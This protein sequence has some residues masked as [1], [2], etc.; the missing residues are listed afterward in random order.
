MRSDLKGFPWGVRCGPLVELLLP[1]LELP[2]ALLRLDR[3][4]LT[5]QQLARVLPTDT[6]SLKFILDR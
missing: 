2:L 3:D 1:L 5:P 6:T 4:L